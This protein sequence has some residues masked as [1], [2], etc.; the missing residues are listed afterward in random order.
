MTAQHLVIP[1]ASPFLQTH[2]LTS[3]V[4]LATSVLLVTTAL[5]T[6]ADTHLILSSKAVYVRARLRPGMYHVLVLV[7]LQR[8]CGTGAQGDRSLLNALSR[9]REKSCLLNLAKPYYI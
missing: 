8:I 3:K 1:L 9:K 6:L 5:F 7:E 2:C 4:N